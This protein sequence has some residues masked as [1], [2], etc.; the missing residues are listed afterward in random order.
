MMWVYFNVPESRYLEFKSDRNQDKEDPKIELVLSNGEKF[1]HFGKLGAIEAVFN[2]ET[3]S[4]P[5]RADFPNPERLLRHGQRGSVIIS[6]VKNNAIVV[7]QQATFEVDQK[8]YV[9]V[10][11]KNNVAHQR[12]VIVQNEFDDQFVV[13]SGLSADDKVVVD[14][15]RQIHEG[16][17]VEYEM[18]HP[19]KAVA[20]LERHAEARITGK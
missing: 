6:R 17:K 20:L 18:S 7:P 8:R 9:Y 5:F 14:G 3:G 10:V 11:D 13:K 16:D 1:S 12:E 15:M 4:I 2:S 19:E